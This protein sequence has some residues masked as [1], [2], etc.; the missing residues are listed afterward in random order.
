VITTHVLDVARG[1]PAV[2]VTVVL[3]AL[4]D[5]RWV[6]IAAALTDE[7]GRISTLS[8]GP[9]IGPGVYRLTFDVAAYQR[10]RGRSSFFPQVQI[11]FNVSDPAEHYHVPLLLSPYSYTTYRGN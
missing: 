5:S 2:G 6:E 8:N 3:E 7:R 9:A 1:E 11:A 4:L 10:E